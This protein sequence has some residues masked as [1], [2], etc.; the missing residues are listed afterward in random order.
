MRTADH[1][2]FIFRTKNRRVKTSGNVAHD[3]FVRTTGG[4][5]SLIFLVKD[6]NVKKSGNFAHDY[7]VRTSGGLFSLVFLVNSIR[8]KSETLRVCCPRPLCDSYWRRVLSRGTGGDV[9]PHGHEEQG[10]LEGGHQHV[11]V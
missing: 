11:P 7:V 4:V 6:K 5:F 2:L 10:V 1:D 9:V 8:S 3:H